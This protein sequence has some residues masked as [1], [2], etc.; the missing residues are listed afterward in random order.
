VREVIAMVKGNFY[1]TRSEIAKSCVV[2]AQLLASQY[3]ENKKQ[4]SNA[5]AD[6][7]RVVFQ[8]LQFA[9]GADFGT[10]KSAIFPR[11]VYK[12]QR[13]PSDSAQPI[14]PRRVGA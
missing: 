4:Q 11:D 5:S 10:L 6:G 13:S 1:G 9:A 12:V 7:Y 3:A 2:S 8:Q 14:R